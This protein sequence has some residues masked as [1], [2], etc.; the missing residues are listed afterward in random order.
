MWYSYL[1]LISALWSLRSRLGG[2]GDLRPSTR[3]AS[4][5]V[6]TEV[7]AASK[8]SMR[9]SAGRHGGGGVIGDT[10]VS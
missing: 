7:K 9:G 1:S 2:R 10:V 6:A 8:A 3:I 4:T 5:F